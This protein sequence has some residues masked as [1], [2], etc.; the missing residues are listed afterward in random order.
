MARP[1][2]CYPLAMRTAPMA[3]VAALTVAA[4]ALP[5]CVHPRRG[6]GASD[7]DDGLSAD[8][9]ARRDCRIAFARCAPPASFAPGLD[10][11]RL[12]VRSLVQI[13]W[14]M[15]LDDEVTERAA[16][17]LRKLAEKGDLDTVREI[18]RAGEIE[19]STVGRCRCAG[20]DL[21]P[22]WDVQKIGTI[23]AGR[24]PPAELET[25]AYW[26]QRIDPR[27][28]KL[29]AL[30]RRAAEAAAAGDDDALAGVDAEVRAEETALC[31]AM[32]AAHDVLSEDGMAEL[33]SLLGEAR[34]RA[35]GEASVALARRDLD[36]ALERPSCAADDRPAAE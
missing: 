36:R 7:P 8:E 11:N 23:A 24:L 33:R 16:K 20:D 29:R 3:A 9:R 18:A 25:P 21:R 28:A 1:P 27:L 30:S 17:R 2:A 19:E 34:A 26:A 13:S 35:S 15:D 4:L 6:D 12:P 5:A 32:H 22:Q 10:V 31:E 14:R